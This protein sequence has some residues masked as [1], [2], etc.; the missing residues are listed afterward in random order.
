[1]QQGKYDSQPKDNLLLWEHKSRCAPLFSLG[2]T[3]TIETIEFTYD[4]L[5]LPVKQPDD[6][7]KALQALRDDN[8]RGF[9]STLGIEIQFE[10][11]QVLTIRT[12]LRHTHYR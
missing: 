10:H 8:A 2:I 12:E 5:I 6:I 11:G 1:V 3:M 9:D 4:G 7:S